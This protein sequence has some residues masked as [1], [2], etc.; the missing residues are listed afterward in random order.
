M[1]KRIVSL[2]LAVMMLLGIASGPISALA[3]DGVTIKLH[4]N[5]P[6][7]VY[8]DWDVWFWPADGSG[9]GYAFAEE[10]GDMVATY[11]VPSGVNSVGFI[12]R[13]GDWAAKDWEADQFIDVS[14]VTSGTVHVYVESGKEGYEKVMGDDAVT[15]TKITMAE[16]REGTGLVVRMSGNPTGDLAKQLTI[17][18]DDDEIKILS[19]GADST[20]SYRVEL[21]KKPDF[22]N[23]YFIIYEG[24]EYKITMPNFYSTNE[25]ES[26]Y[27][28]TGNA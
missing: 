5:R 9:A 6:D 19:V 3:A 24:T 11:N 7:G 12:V 23:T 18:C 10:D 21:D 22:R 13:Q 1:K 17:K 15:G 4:Y 25:F 14:E 20:G 2:A 26:Q 16:Y 28:Y 8:D 27:T